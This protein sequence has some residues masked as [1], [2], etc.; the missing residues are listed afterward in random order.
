M[1]DLNSLMRVRKHDVD[2][3]QKALAELYQKAEDLRNQRDSL[4]TQL[5]LESEKTK[6]MSP[7]L[8]EFFAPYAKKTRSEIKVIDDARIRLEKRILLA[9]DAM[10][11]A[12]AELKKIEIIDDRRK[13]E[14][15]AEIN[16]QE[17]ALMDEI[18]LQRFNKADD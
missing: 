1:N 4:E 6:E 10:R 11:D 9:Q 14:F 12:F 18:A 3:R 13:A 17:A 8:L 5:A 2:Q 16:K 7:E 15:L